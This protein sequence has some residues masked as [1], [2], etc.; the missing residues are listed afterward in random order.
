MDKTYSI[1]EARKDFS[2][3]VRKAEAGHQVAL[4]RRG[5]TVAVVISAS[6]FARRVSKCSAVSAAIDAFRRNHGASLDDADWLPA[7][8]HAP[9][10]NP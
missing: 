3:L 5:R 2:G 7:R 1:S 9:V 8:D 6:E 4:S 10:T